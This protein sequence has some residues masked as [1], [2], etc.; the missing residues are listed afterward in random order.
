M[1]G[2]ASKWKHGMVLTKQA[3]DLVIKASIVDRTTES[4]TI[5]L[6]W[7]KDELS[8]AEVLHQAGAIPLPPYLQRD[9]EETDKNRYQ[10]I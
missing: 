6:R 2:G 8:F 7:N 4:F 1:I 3:G 10:K 5:E 9:A